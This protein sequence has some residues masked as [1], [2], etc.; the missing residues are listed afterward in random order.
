MAA[1]SEKVNLTKFDIIIPPQ[2]ITCEPGLQEKLANGDRDA[3]AWVYKNYCKRVYN[4]AL[5]VTANEEQSEDVVQELFVRLWRY[6]EKL[7]GIE[8]FNGY[9]RVLYRNETL[10]ALRNVK[11]ETKRRQKYTEGMAPGVNDVEEMI[12]CKET[13]RLIQDAVKEL[14][15]CRRR[16]FEM[17]QDGMNNKDIA[18]T[19]GKSRKTVW[20]QLQMAEKFLRERVR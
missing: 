8:N 18:R 11:R 5:L 6:K 9:M 17:T 14:P 2:D 10:N 16:I 13:N 20:N 7:R 19:L 3:F 15:K 1:E 12:N 4:Y